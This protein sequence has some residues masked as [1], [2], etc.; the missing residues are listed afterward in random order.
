MYR[1][2]VVAP[3]G[4]SGFWDS[5][6]NFFKGVKVTAPA[7]TLPTVTLPT[8]YQIPGTS[9]PPPVSM[10]PPPSQ[11][12]N[13]VMPVAIGGIGLLALMMLTRRGRR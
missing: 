2:A 1:R 10:Q 4:M 5:I 12:P 7:I 3:V 6:T 11:T 8:T 9:P 13:W